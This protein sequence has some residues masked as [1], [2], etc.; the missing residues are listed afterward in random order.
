MILLE[1]LPGWPEAPAISEL[2][3]L[4]LTVVGPLAAG[5]L[6]TALVFARTW[7]RRED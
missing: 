7:A 3:L 5:A 4:L 2:N 1:T 6:I